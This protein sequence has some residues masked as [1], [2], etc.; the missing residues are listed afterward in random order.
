MK[1]YRP[2]TRNVPSLDLGLKASPWGD[3]VNFLTESGAVATRQRAL[4]EIGE[5]LQILTSGL[6]VHLG[7]MGSALARTHEIVEHVAGELDGV[8]EA[9]NR[10][11]ATA[12]LDMM[13]L[14]ADRLT[15]LPLEQAKRP[16]IVDGISMASFDLLQN[17]KQIRRTLTFLQICGLNIKVVAAGAEGFANFADH[18][19]V[20]LEQ[21]EYQV[22]EFEAEITLLGDNIGEMVR[23]DRLLIRE[24][25][26]VIPH[27]PLQLAKDA[28][29]L[30]KLLGDSAAQAERAAALARDVRD[31][32]A[33]AIGVLQ[34]GA[35]VRQRWEHI[36][37]GLDLLLTYMDQ[38][39]GEYGDA[40]CAASRAVMDHAISLMAAQA[41]DAADQFHTDIA[42]I[43]T[44]LRAIVPVAARLADMNLGESGAHLQKMLHQLTDHV[45]EITKV[46]RQLCEAEV[47]SVK[48]G[49]ATSH[50]ADNLRDRLKAV[51]RIQRDVEQMAWNTALQCRN[52]GADGRGIAVI[53]EEIQSFSRHLADIWELVAC[54]FGRVVSS[55]EAVGQ[56]DQIESEPNMADTFILSLETICGGYDPLIASLQMVNQDAAQMAQ[57]LQ[58]LTDDFLCDS[59]LSPAIAHAVK[60]LHD[61]SEESRL[62]PDLAETTD[63]DRQ[64][65]A[66]VFEQIRGL[67][68]MARERD[69]HRAFVSGRQVQRFQ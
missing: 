14:T 36:A 56:P 66:K 13:Q 43:L 1:R 5:D 23:A 11:V 19:F 55:A 21:A 17:L 37:Q 31:K 28:Q 50:A 30:Q 40:D 52:L 42:A 15:Q 29:T 63:G 10:Q 49:Q 65:V 9:I 7:A 45:G 39:R 41:A 6:D 32:V 68:T 12:A 53:S 46:T 48:L 38:Q 67:Y 64:Q 8:I 62:S 16:E 2:P 44:H 18:M 60:S 22:D 25:T 54:N 47:N 58:R 69:V 4:A 34:A 57:M 26:A 61:L 51:N 27:V 59:P 3:N 24:C 20:K 35:I 33:R